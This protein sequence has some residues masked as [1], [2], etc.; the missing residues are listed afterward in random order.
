MNAR[1]NDSIGQAYVA[2]ARRRLAACHERVQHCLA[3]LNDAQVWWRP[4]P[5]QNSVANVV[6]HLC[7]NLRQW[8]VSGVGGA[9]DVRD[10][11]QEFAERV[12]VPRDELLRR[13]GEVVD[14]ADAVLAHVG[15]EQLLE[16]RRIQGFDGTVLSAVF[17]SLAHLAG[18]TQEIV[19][20]T[21]LQL[22]DAYRFAWA[23]ETPEQG[24]PPAVPANEVAEATDAVF[25]QGLGLPPVLPAAPAAEPAAPRPPTPV[26]EEGGAGRGT[27]PAKP[28]GDY[29]REIGDEFQREEDEGK[30]H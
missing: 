6:L 18:H 30:L 11:P 27:V 16:P 26:P 14:E 24:A 8:I 19:C 17:D 28:L 15:D 3:Q 29:V 7:G 10:R 12:P 9:A 1:T 21:R 23:P 25:E 13:L 2:E 22:G 20:L 4:R 5:S